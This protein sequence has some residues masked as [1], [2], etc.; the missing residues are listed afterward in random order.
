[1]NEQ[2]EVVVVGAGAA[3]LG[4]A[5]ELARRGVHAE[6]LERGTTVGGSWRSRY[7][8]LRLNTV[9]WMS[10]MPGG[11]IPRRAGRWP[12]REDFAAHL[13]SYASEM[14]IEPRL[15]IDVRGIQRSASGWR[16]EASAGAIEAR[17]VVV[18]A[19]YDRVPKMPDW[20]GRAGF[21]GEL[22]HASEYSDPGPYGGKD[23]LVVGTG[24]T[25]TEVATQLA[26]GGARRVRVSRRTPVNFMPTQVL[27][28][29]I[30]VVARLSE[31]APEW[32]VNRGGSLIQRM[33]VGDLARLGM[34]RAPY[35]I[36]TEMQIKG[37]GPVLD[38]GFVSALKRGELELVAAVER[39]DGD[40]VQ[41]ADGSALRP[42]AVISATGYGHGL[43][44]LVG[45]L[46][47][48]D[49]RG[50]PLAVGGGSLENAPGLYFNGYWLPFSGQL[51]AMRRSSRRI[52]R[53]IAG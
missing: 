26:H 29:P 6:V 41:L 49:E 28:I 12:S 32:I 47:V 4:V 51:P 33:T 37:L 23:V 30:T 25:G 52:A 42:D 18:A 21:E 9:R 20:P 43:E 7:H 44:D 53:R 40:Q 45:H 50:R 34:P 10:A 24:N 17:A 3:G 11:S 8:G 2:L 39:F 14:G 22:I 13:D 15:G 46:G 31:L 35:G 19:G 36:A 27:G 1:M 38:R 48:L 5:G 16:L